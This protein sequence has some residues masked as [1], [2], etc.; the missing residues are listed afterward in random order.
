MHLV[1]MWSW[2]LLGG[3]ILPVMVYSYCE[4]HYQTKNI[5]TLNNDVLNKLDVVKCMK[6]F[7]HPALH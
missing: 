3:T 6:A 4:L 5:L 1:A 7:S 2:C